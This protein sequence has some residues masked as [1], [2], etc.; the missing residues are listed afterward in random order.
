LALAKGSANQR[1]RV[2]YP[3]SVT[4]VLEPALADCVAEQVQG[5]F[6]RGSA[7]ASSCRSTRGKGQ[8]AR[9]LLAS[10]DHVDMVMLRV[11]GGK[12]GDYEREEDFILDDSR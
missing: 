6:Q 1:A 10:S 3:W 8:P 2:S 9:A 7:S 12:N 4:A 11:K 5:G